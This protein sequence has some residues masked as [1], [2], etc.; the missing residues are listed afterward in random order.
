MCVLMKLN[1][2]L[3]VQMFLYLLITR[4]YIPMHILYDIT[5]HLPQYLTA[6][7]SKECYDERY[8]ASTN[9]FIL[10]YSYHHYHFFYTK[11]FKFR[12]IPTSF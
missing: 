1:N 9:C 2:L 12:I 4:K 11:G 6:E 10:F 7:S 8:R 3:F 5:C